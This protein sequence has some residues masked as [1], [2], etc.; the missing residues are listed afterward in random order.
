M[1]Q[2]FFNNRASAE[3]LSRLTHDVGRLSRMSSQDPAL[4]I[5]EVFTL[6]MLLVVVFVREWRLATIALII[7]PLIALALVRIG[8]KLRA[9]NKRGQENIAELSV[10]AQETLTATKIMK[11]FGA[12]LTSASASNRRTAGCTS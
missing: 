5:R 1:S 8:K 7:F 11:A 9:I 6:V 2:S 12:R 3:L 10:V 4:G